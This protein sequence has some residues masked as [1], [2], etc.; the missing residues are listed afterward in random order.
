MRRAIVELAGG[1]A[2]MVAIL[3]GWRDG[4]ML[5][6][7]IP[8]PPDDPFRTTLAILLLVVAALRAIEAWGRRAGGRFLGSRHAGI[9]EAFALG[10]LV[11]LT[12]AR[13]SLG[14][15]ATDWFLA[16]GFL[17]LLGGRVARLVIGLR[18]C[19]D[20]PRPDRAPHPPWVFFLL[21]LVVY[22]AIQPWSAEHRQPD[23]DEP[24]YLLLAHSLVHDF[25]AE[26]SNQYADGDSRRF[27][28]RPI[29]PQ[30][31][32]P[33]TADGRV[34]SRHSLLL[35]LV[36]APAYAVAGRSGAM[37]M[38][39]L[40]A[41]ALAWMV[42][43]LALR[44]TWRGAAAGA[45]H[46]ATPS[47]A[48]GVWALVAF[49]PPLM[50]YSYQIW[51]EVPAALLLT[52]GLDLLPKL[53]AKPTRRRILAMAA[54]LLVLPLLKMRYILLAAGLG[55]VL[56]RRVRPPR[57]VALVLGTVFGGGVGGILLFNQLVFGT[58][59]KVY[60]LQDVLHLDGNPLLG[61]LGFFYDAAFGLF[62]AAP[63]WM[64]LVPALWLL[65]RRREPFLLDLFLVLLP[66][67]AVLV[68]RV[69]WY[70]GW[71]P[72]FRYALAGLPLFA[73]ALVPLLEERRR[74]GMRL[75]VAGLGCLT[76]VLTLVWLIIPG[77]TYNF[78]DGRT[79][80]LDAAGARLGVDFARLVPSMVRPRTATWLW[81]LLSLLLIPLALGS[82]RLV[83][84]RRPTTSAALGV[85]G[86]LALSILLAV[87]AAHLPTRTVHVEDGWVSK[88]LGQPVPELW[89]T[90]RPRYRGGWVIPPK[91]RVTA[92]IVS[93]GERV[94]LRVSA[95]M[96]RGK[97]PYRLHLLAGDQPLA[98]WRVEPGD[99][100]EV[101]LGPFDW[102]RGAPLV[103]EGPG[104]R[105]AQR[106][107]RAMVD[108][109]DLVWHRANE[110]EDGG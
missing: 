75:L 109:V 29:K 52:C 13:S 74:P 62:A 27:M 87:A 76:L 31:G 14:L 35:P 25:D 78:A 49:T 95:L 69:E 11:L 33:A 108:R 26:L 51:V 46:T 67:W 71:S 58:P 68:A 82:R 84:S 8:L 16:A 37:T 97:R 23:G 70:G 73:L 43:R 9:C 55:L 17:L 79:L 72:P 104:E 48:L 65:L 45:E 101:E 38:M 66:Y 61:L 3:A 98:T 88:T 39:A 50:L 44:F 110:G 12:L 42:L 60:R 57:R 91:G 96:V 40:F 5:A 99:W 93:G 22:L 80:L 105:S 34:Y 2:A 94:S 89:I 30:L 19:L 86:V 1:A 85:T 54:I 21:P 107:A 56:W 90:Q 36:L 28:R 83:R 20:R 7:W 92:P 41:A 64:L 63:L 106:P 6:D 59:F 53:A 100:R 102:P 10:A 32:D 81:P 103:L 4:G 47:A 15:A 18:P 77:W 24:Y